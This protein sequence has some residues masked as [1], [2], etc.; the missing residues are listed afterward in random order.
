MAPTR[1][2]FVKM[3]GGF[4]AAVCFPGVLVQGCRGVLGR[5][6]RRTPVI[7]IQGQSCSGCSVSLLNSIDVDVSTLLTEHV[8]LYFHQTLSWATGDV[9][10]GVLRKVIQR[11]I[12]DYVLV[13]EGSIPLA[14]EMYCT[15]GTPGGGHLGI[16]EWVMEL[17]ESARH[18]IAV[19]TCAAF[20]GIP[21]AAGRDAG[22]QP[23]GAAP[24][25]TVLPDRRIVNVPGCPPHPDWIAGTIVRCL[26]G[27]RMKLDAFARPLVYFG[28]TVH[29][30]C[31]RLDDY[32]QEKF[33]RYWG[34]EGCLYYLGCLGIDTHCDIP[35]RKWVG[36]A[37]SCTG[38]GS[39]CI[40]CT[41]E[42]FPDFGQRGLYRHREA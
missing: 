33:A 35:A 28:R 21:A 7:W 13:V 41:E 31:E 38:C 40:G 15:L 30:Q 24:L 19:G 18:I 6:A 5:A 2:S 29:E 9:A 1:R 17:A 14:S 12:E 8:S 39:G 37:N 25:S 4:G 36:G 42:V 27:R 34:D 22:G 3:M 23:T 16:R 20:G 26:L 32:K 11:Q 10:T